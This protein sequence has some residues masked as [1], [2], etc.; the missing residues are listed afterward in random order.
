M[1]VFYGYE[2][3]TEKEIDE[4]NTSVDNELPITGG[5]MKVDIDM[6]VWRIKTIQRQYM[7]TT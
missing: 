6:S 1:S 5:K 2:D 4:L 3:K 7:I